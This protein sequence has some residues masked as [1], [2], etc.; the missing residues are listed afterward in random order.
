MQEVLGYSPPERLMPNHKE[1]YH[2]DF[3]SRCG[4]GMSNQITHITRTLLAIERMRRKKREKQKL[5]PYKIYSL[6]HSYIKI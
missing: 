2:K 3:F 6:C 1:I 5:A 4:R